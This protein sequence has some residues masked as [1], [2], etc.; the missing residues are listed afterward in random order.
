MKANTDFFPLTF[1]CAVTQHDRKTQYRIAISQRWDRCKDGNR[2]V[3]RPKPASLLAECKAVAMSQP[4]SLS[5]PG[6]SPLKEWL[7]RA[8]AVAAYAQQFDLNP[9]IGKE[10]ALKRTVR[11]LAAFHRFE[12]SALRGWVRAVEAR[13]FAKLE[14]HRAGRSGRRSEQHKLGKVFSRRK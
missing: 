14:D 12:V 1:I 7:K 6:S 5:V 13:Q 2:H 11:D 3:Y 4:R 8:V 10:A 9:K